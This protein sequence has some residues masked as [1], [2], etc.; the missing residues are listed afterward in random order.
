MEGLVNWNIGL[1][2][3]E[4]KDVTMKFLVR[5]TRTNLYNDVIK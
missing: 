2:K 3:Q 4:N 1:L 5:E